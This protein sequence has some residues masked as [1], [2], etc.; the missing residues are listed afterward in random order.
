[1]RRSLVLLGLI[2]GLTVTLGACGQNG[3]LR[4]A[5]GRTMPVAPFGREDKPTAAELLTPK[6]QAAP[7]RSIELRRKS[8]P[9]ADDP[10]DLPPDDN[11]DGIDGGT[12]ASPAPQP[13]PSPS[14]TNP[15]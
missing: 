5:A 10:F 12:K 3:D 15:I 7:E 11:G 13:T 2:A 14:P 9:R 6:P 8:E 1:M 4:P